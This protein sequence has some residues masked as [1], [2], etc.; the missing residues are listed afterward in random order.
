MLKLICGPSGSGKSYVLRERIR[1]D[2]EAGQRAFLIVPEQQVYFYEQELLPVLP[3][4][5]GR[6][7]KIVGFRRLAPPTR[8]A[9]TAT[10]AIAG[11]P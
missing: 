2:M 10:Q 7:L 1:R 9:D 11:A 6:I 4:S 8:P 5:A 3:G